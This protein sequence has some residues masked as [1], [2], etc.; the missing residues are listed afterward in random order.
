MR[1]PLACGGVTI[2]DRDE[3]LRPDVEHDEVTLEVDDVAAGLAVRVALVVDRLGRHVH[4]LVDLGGVHGRH[5]AEAAGPPP[6]NW[7][8]MRIGAVE[9]RMVEPLQLWELSVDDPEAGLRAYLAFTGAISCHPIVGGYEQVGT[10]G[11]QLR[12]ADRRVALTA[13][14]ARRTHTWR[15][16]P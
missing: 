10:V 11:G 15:A 14:P 4:L 13:A 16:L 5:D 1:P 6:T 12:L 2:T 8:R 3:W 9:W 7:D